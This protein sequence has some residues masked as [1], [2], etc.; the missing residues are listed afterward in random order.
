MSRTT[1]NWRPTKI[2]PEYYAVSDTG[3]VKNLRSGRI[4]KPTHDKYGYLYYVL[5]VK[6]ERKTVKAHRLVAEAFI[7]NC[8]SKPTVD[9]INGI[10]T[11]NRASNLRWATNKEQT[12]NPITR[13]HLDAAHKKTNYREMGAKRDFGRKPVLI[14][15]ED[16]RTQTFRSLKEAAIATG[17]NYTKLSEIINGKRAQDKRFTAI[18]ASEIEE[19]PIAVTKYH[20]GE[21]NERL[22][23]AGRCDE[24]EQ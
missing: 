10:K 22:H 11:D 23:D 21:E 3:R 15:W 17:K 14:A 24:Y 2:F 18:W 13:R 9:H 12:N 16:G 6:G 19:S 7:E 5:C 4:L 8:E 1:C 20:F